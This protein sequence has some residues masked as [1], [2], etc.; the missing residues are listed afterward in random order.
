MISYQT[1]HCHTAIREGYRSLLQSDTELLLPT[2]GYNRICDYYR[3]VR[4]AC[5]KWAETAEGERLRRLYLETEDHTERARFRTAQYRLRCEPVWGDDSHVSY[6]C[7]SRYWGD[8]QV[9][10]RIMAQVWNVKEQTL[11]PM[12]QILRTFP[13]NAPKK[14]CPFRP[15][16]IYVLE[17]E[18]VFYRNRDGDGSPIEFRVERKTENEL[19]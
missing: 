16:G 7:R 19:S 5:V 4:D 17:N 14:R 12:S 6:V 10:E 3:R 8:G 13:T 11:L 9:R 15:D 2:S 1:E 18:L